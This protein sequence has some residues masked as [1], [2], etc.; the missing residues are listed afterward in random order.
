MLTS[1]YAQKQLKDLQVKYTAQMSTLEEKLFKQHKEKEAEANDK[2]LDEQMA[3]MHR[4]IEDLWKQIESL[5]VCLLLSLCFV[6]LHIVILSCV[7]ITTYV[8]YKAVRAGTAGTALAACHFFLKIKS[9]CL[10][11]HI[12]IKLFDFLGSSFQPLKLPN[13]HSTVYH[14]LPFF[15]MSLTIIQRLHRSIFH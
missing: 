15:V 10:L 11:S 1:H 8:Q 14:F 9:I 6:Y 5:Q 13:I 12:V 2:D 3:K 7:S 4:Q